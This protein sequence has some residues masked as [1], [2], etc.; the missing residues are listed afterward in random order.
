MFLSC[1]WRNFIILSTHLTATFANRPSQFAEKNIEFPSLLSEEHILFY[2]L[3]V[4]NP[5]QTLSM[6]VSTDQIYVGSKITFRAPISQFFS[7]TRFREREYEFLFTDIRQTSLLLPW[8]RCIYSTHTR[9]RILIKS[10]FQWSLCQKKDY[11]EGP[12]G[13][14]ATKL[15]GEERS[16]WEILLSAGPRF[17]SGRKHV[18]SDSHRFEQIDPQARVLNYCFQ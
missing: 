1:S 4:S 3:R 15:S 8:S 6:N 12:E 7:G 16:T 11:Q 2:F 17:D 13:L 5:F 14:S 9:L 10:W 18:N